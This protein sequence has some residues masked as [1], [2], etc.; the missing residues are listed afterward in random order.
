MKK[1]CLHGLV[2][3]LFVLT[4]LRKGGKKF[5]KFGLH[6]SGDM[7]LLRVRKT[8]YSCLK[9]WKKNSLYFQT[10]VK[11][12]YL[13][14]VPTMFV[15]IKIRFKN[16]KF[17]QFDFSKI[18]YLIKILCIYHI[19]LHIILCFFLDRNFVISA[20]AESAIRWWLVPSM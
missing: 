13:S 11:P 5:Y 10:T 1:K 9:N 15:R 19:I 7:W 20:Y 6:P 12:I 17:K 4:A 14:N 16:L 2:R 3:V 8:C 18:I